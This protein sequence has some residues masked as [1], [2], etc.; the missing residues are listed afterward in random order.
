MGGVER[1]RER[2]SETT[3]ASTSELHRAILVE[4]CI[5]M[6]WECPNKC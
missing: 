1:E 6:I 4:V 2:F 5:Y 3:R